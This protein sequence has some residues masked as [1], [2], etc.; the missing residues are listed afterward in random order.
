MRSN[1]KL[2]RKRVGLSTAG[3]LGR[4]LLD[5]HPARP[6]PADITRKYR[7]SVPHPRGAD[8]GLASTNLI[9]KSFHSRLHRA[10]REG[11]SNNRPK[12]TQ[13]PPGSTDRIESFLLLALEP[14]RV[15]APD[16]AG[17]R[18]PEHG[19]PCFQSLTLAFAAPGT[20]HVR[21]VA[22]IAWTPG[23]PASEPHSARRSR[24]CRNSTRWTICLGSTMRP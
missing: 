1:P 5:H 4:F 14:N 7:R 9:P 6:A 16:Q 20:L 24:L 2:Y 21:P 12:P 19:R 17:P 18:D 3:A 15:G 22:T 13:E 11:N 8:L 10:T 23:P